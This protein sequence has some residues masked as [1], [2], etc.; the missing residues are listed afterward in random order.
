VSFFLKLN[1]SIITK[2]FF[3]KADL[4]QW[5]KPNIMFTDYGDILEEIWDVLIE[6]GLSFIVKD[7]NGRSVGVSKIQ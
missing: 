4:E 2:S 5:L 1:S 3:E 6:K 7:G